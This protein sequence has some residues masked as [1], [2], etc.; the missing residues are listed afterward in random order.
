MRKL[1]GVVVVLCCVMFAGCGPSASRKLVGRWQCNLAETSRQQGNRE[2]LDNPVAA[3][4][5]A[6]FTIELAFEADGMVAATRGG[7]QKLWTKQWKVTNVEGQKVTI[8]LCDTDDTNPQVELLTFDGDDHF[9]YTW[10]GKSVTF[11]R[12]KEQQ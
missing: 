3:G 2:N 4:L 9:T 7:S 11:T 10:L 8:E 6:I 1:A 12:V 5:A